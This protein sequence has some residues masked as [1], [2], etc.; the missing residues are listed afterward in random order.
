MTQPQSDTVD[1]RR[2]TEWIMHEIVDPNL[3]P[4]DFIRVPAF[5]L[6]NGPRIIPI[7][8]YEC[9]YVLLPDLYWGDME[10]NDIVKLCILFPNE[11][12]SRNMVLPSLR[13]GQT[14]ID[15][16]ACYG[17]WT[18]PA[19]AMWLN[20]IAIE[21][22]SYAYSVLEQHI[23]INNF[24]KRVTAVREFIDVTN[25][26]DNLVKKLKLEAVHFIKIDVEGSEFTVLEGA[27]ETIN[28]FRP[29]LLV[30]LHTPEHGKIPEDE[31]EF[32]TKMCSKF[33]YSS[34]IS[35]QK[36]RQEDKEYYHCYHYI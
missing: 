9:E 6:D 27:K 1:S 2:I 23:S 5:T 18:L 25:T 12:K 19:A 4:D 31:I 7:K 22:E 11:R 26:I 32:L 21:P 34:Y 33:K 16:G 13:P 35:S 36:D 17:S 15:I 30:E 28:K 24:Q 8:F 10:S 20:V 14:M 29:K 3:N